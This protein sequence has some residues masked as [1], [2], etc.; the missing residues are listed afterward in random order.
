LHPH[1][2]LAIAAV[3][4]PFVIT[5]RYL[6][7]CWIAPF[8]PCRKCDGRG[9]LATPLG[10]LTRQCRRCRGTGIRLRLGRHVINHYRRIHADATRPPAATD[11]ETA[12]EAVR[13]GAP[14]WAR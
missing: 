9:R 4:I 7:L 14:P 8:R 11:R 10:R 12:R 5:F 2:T 13:T 6:V 1:L 3:L